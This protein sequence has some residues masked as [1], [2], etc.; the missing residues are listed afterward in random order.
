LWATSTKVRFFHFKSHFV[1]V[2]W[3]NILFSYVMVFRRFDK[4][5]RYIFIS[6]VRS[7]TFDFILI[8]VSTKALHWKHINFFLEEIKC[9]EPWIV[10]YEHCKVGK[11]I[12]RFCFH[13]AT[14]VR[15]YELK[16]SFDSRIIALRKWNFVLFVSNTSFTKWEV[17]E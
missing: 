3:H 5:T 10:I 11:S 9:N 2:T 1:Q 8:W 4:M 12:Q 16:C 13:G 14:N 15:M 17:V 6:I 7:Q